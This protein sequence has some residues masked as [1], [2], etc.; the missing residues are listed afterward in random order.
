M[1][2]EHGDQFG[3]AEEVVHVLAAGPFGVLAD[4]AVVAVGAV[5][6]EGDDV[7]QAAVVRRFDCVINGL[8]G[9][10]IELAR[11]GLDAKFA[12][13][14]VTEGLRAD[15]AGT[16]HFGG[17]EG[18]VYF[19]MRGIAGAHVLRGS[20]GLD[21]EPLDVGPAVAEGFSAQGQAGSV[22]LDKFVVVFGLSKTLSTDC[23]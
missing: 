8:E 16:H 18:V 4:A 7:A 12:A 1:L 3:V 2:L 6:D 14:A 10:G 9:L 22:V 20:V 23:H 13:D 5:A 15:D 17:V 19:K 21:T 11:F